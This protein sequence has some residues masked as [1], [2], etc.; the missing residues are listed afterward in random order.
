MIIYLPC[1]FWKVAKLQNLRAVT[2]QIHL[3]DFKILEIGRLFV[4][5]YCKC[6]VRYEYYH[7][8]IGQTT[9]KN[10]VKIHGQAISG[11]SQVFY[12]H[13]CVEEPHI[14]VSNNRLIG[15]F[16]WVKQLL[17]TND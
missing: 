15:L 14:Y 1:E 7:Y 11:E 6:V 3:L 2:E 8:Y 17:S 9:R 16:G 5:I 4:V 13:M 10:V 12:Q